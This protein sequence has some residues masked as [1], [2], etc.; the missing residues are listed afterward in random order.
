MEEEIA[1]EAARRA[2][3]DSQGQRKYPKL[4]LP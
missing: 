3:D 4:P 1:Q 2:A